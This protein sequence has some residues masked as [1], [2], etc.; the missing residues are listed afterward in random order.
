[1]KYRESIRMA[2]KALSDLYEMVPAD[3]RQTADTSVE[4]LRQA[5]YG[6]SQ[7]MEFQQAIESKLY[8]ADREQK[9]VNIRMMDAEA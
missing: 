5:I 1:M 8:F 3:R 4:V 7:A 6:Y 9:T 2:E